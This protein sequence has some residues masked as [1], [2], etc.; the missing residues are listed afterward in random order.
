MNKILHKTFDYEIK[1]KDE[2]ELTVRHFI[3]T[4]KR[5][6]IGDKMHSDGMIVNGIPVVLL[7][8]GRGFMGAEPV[9]KS[10]WL[11]PGIHKRDKGIEAFTQFFDDEQGIGKRLWQKTIEK[12]MPNWSLG[13]GIVRAKAFEDKG[14]D[15]TKWNLYEYSI[16]GVS[17]NPDANTIKGMDGMD[18]LP[19]IMVKYMPETYLQK[20]LDDSGILKTCSFDGTK[21]LYT[22]DMGKTID[23]IN[24]FMTEDFDKKQYSQNDI[25]SKNKGTDTNDS[26]QGG[27]GD[28]ATEKNIY[29][30]AFEELNTKIDKLENIVSTMVSAVDTKFKEYSKTITELEN[31]KR[32]QKIIFKAPQVEKKQELV[33]PK[34]AIDKIISGVQ[35]KYIKEFRKVLGRVD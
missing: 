4:E 1:A 31:K 22:D 23:E 18:D 25:D 33:I 19:G 5:D 28:P 32:E 10:L 26:S 14:L 24:N 6:R 30:K 20:A 17:I 13:Y 2:T 7:E 9:A 16:V 34:Y 15:I 11:R 21:S 35:E 8:H 27:S 12:Y 29:K 3:T